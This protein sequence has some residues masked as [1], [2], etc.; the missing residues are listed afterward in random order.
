MIIGKRK[1]ARWIK[2]KQLWCTALVRRDMTAARTFQ[3]EIESMHVARRW[4]V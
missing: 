1:I 4:P 2:L 3:V